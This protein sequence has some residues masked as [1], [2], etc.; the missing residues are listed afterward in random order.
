[1]GAALSLTAALLAG[2][3]AGAAPPAAAGAVDQPL[4]IG[5]Y[6]IRAGVGQGDFERAVSTFKPMAD[7]IG[8]QEIGATD[9]GTYL[10]SDSTWGYYRPPALQQNPILWNRALFDFAGAEGVVIA[11]KR[12]LGGE[13]SGD[14][15]KGDSL[16][17]VV[18]LVQRSTGQQLSFINVHLV[19]GAVKGGLPAPGKPK[20][21]GLYTDQVAGTV[22]VIRDER[23]ESDEVFVLGDFNAGYEADVKRKHKKLPYMKYT[24]TGKRP[25]LG[26]RSMWQGS[27]LLKKSYG[28]HND[29]LIDQVWSTGNSSAEA[30]VRT[31]KASDHVPAV[32]TYQLPVD[33]GY[34]PVTGV[35]GF[36]PAD[37]QQSNNEGGGLA[38][39]WD[40][41][42]K[43]AGDS[44]HGF[45]DVKITGAGVS[46][47]YQ[48]G[49]DFLVDLSTFYD[50][51]PNAAAVRL[52]FQGDRQDEP[53]VDFTIQL[54]GSTSATVLPGLDTATGTMTNDD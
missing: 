43:V 38:R 40:L 52:D 19:R 46:T 13:H 6:N 49:G 37:L 9:R 21:F 33:P 36:D 27:P 28:T 26:L 4:R 48:D 41:V 53:N 11:D 31:I 8:L 34:V 17:T 45:V 3:P 12:D 2:I 23:E 14:E 29:A 15:E 24:G 18:R 22:R 54:I 10:A 16:A 7:V 51:N 44:G 20:L 32:A 39:E 47:K 5:T 35:V 30:I 25:G 1:M 50:D 42:Y